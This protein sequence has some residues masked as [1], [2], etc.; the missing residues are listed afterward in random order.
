MVSVS[1]Q[2]KLNI[3]AY[4]SDQTSY[5]GF[6]S[7]CYVEFFFQYQ[8]N[9]DKHQIESSQKNTQKKWM[10][11]IKERQTHHVTALS[12]S[13]GLVFLTLLFSLFFC[14][15]TCYPITELCTCL[16]SGSLGKLHFNT[17]CTT[18]PSGRRWLR[19]MWPAVTQTPFCLCRFRGET[20][21]WLSS[22][23]TY[24][25]TQEVF[26]NTLTRHRVL[27]SSLCCFSFSNL[28]SS[29]ECESYIHRSICGRDKSD[30]LTAS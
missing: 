8:T 6:F 3:W 1:P 29:S 18:W 11:K 24:A 4:V 16:L 27:T 26:K 15:F 17:V 19:L 2:I 7:L 9:T 13:L 22:A 20:S 12:D 14:H 21:A 5:S 23:L 30:V 28:S 25:Q 10:K